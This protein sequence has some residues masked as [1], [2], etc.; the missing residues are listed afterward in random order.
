MIEG[1]KENEVQKKYRNGDECPDGL[2]DADQMAVHHQVLHPAVHHLHRA[3][4]QQTELRFLS[5]TKTPEAIPLMIQLQK[6][7]RK[8]QVS[9][10][11]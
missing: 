1:G 8:K 9:K 10:F 3:R 7:L 6:Q 4:Y 11:R 5:L 2:Q